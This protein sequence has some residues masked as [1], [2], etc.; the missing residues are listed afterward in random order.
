MRTDLFILT[1]TANISPFLEDLEPEIAMS[2]LER[3]DYP[4]SLSP[5]SD[6]IVTIRMGNQEGASGKWTFAIKDGLRAEGYQW[7][8]KS[9]VWHATEPAVGFSFAEFAK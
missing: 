9:K 7:D 8:G 2:R 3:S 5:S 1:E 4:A 6:A